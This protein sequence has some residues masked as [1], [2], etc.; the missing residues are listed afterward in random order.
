MEDEAS[1][2]AAALALAL[3]HLA[4]RHLRF[5]DR[6]PR[7]RWLSAAGGISVAYVFVHVL[8]ELS[9]AQAAVGEAAGEALEFVEHHVYLVSLVG[10]AAFYGLER[11]AVSSRR[12]SRDRGGEDAASR[13]VFWLGIASFA[14]YNGLIGYVLVERAEERAADLALF[15][16]AMA[17]HFVVNDRGLREHYRGAYHSIGRWVLAAAPLAGCAIGLTIAVSDAVLGVLLAFLSGGVVLNVLK[18]ELPEERE[19]RFLAFALGAA[20]YA[21][22]LIAA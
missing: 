15:A 12:Q 4:A 6:I 18:E 8:P 5:V 11:A 22:L 9:E 7:S 14:V 19:S 21:M 20:A 16:L 3:V 1:A 17:V 2:L 10:L 13:E